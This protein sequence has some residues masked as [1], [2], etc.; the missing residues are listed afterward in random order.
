[1]KRWD[2]NLDF[3]TYYVLLFY[4]KRI[5]HSSAYLLFTLIESLFIKIINNN[6]H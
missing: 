2:G 6:N 4:K 1:M 5:H 3:P